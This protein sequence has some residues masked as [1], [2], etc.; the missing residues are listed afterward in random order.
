ML[1]PKGSGSA[2]APIRLGAWGTGPLPKIQAEPGQE[3]AFRLV[4][5][6]YWTV[7]HLEFSGGQPHGVFISGT[8]GV[9]HGIHIRDAVVH[10]VTGEPENKEGGLLVI[11]PGSARQTFDDV[12]VDGVTAY[13]TSQW[14]GILVGSVSLGF[15]PESARSTNVVV[16]NSIVHDVAGDGI[17]LFQVNKGLIEN[18]VAWHTGMQETETIGTPDG[19]WVWMCRDCTLRRNE[20]FLTDSPGIDGGAFDIDYGNSS[21]IVEDSYGHDTQGYCVS[22]FGAG[23]VT[24]DSVVRNNVCAGNGRSP[25]LAERQGA[26]FLSTWN[27]G[28]LKGVTLSGNRIFWD[29]PTGAAAV[30]NT[31]NFEGAGLFQDNSIHSRSPFFI[32][33]NR[34]LLFDRN[35]YRYSGAGAPAWQY[36]D[37]LYRGFEEYVRG[38]RQ[39]GHGRAAPA[40][41]DAAVSSSAALPPLSFKDAAGIAVPFEAGGWTLLAFV[42]AAEEDHDSRGQVAGVLSAHRQ[43]DSA[44]LRVVVVAANPVEEERARNLRYDWNTGSVPVVFDDGRARRALGLSA[45][46]SLILANPAGRVLWRHEGVAPPGDLGLALRSNLGNPDYAQLLCEP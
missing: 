5:Q 40:L 14:A 44:G 33:S 21:T 29:P 43:F 2:A 11:A 41:P 4:D 37:T 38:S 10:G 16:R 45:T 32:R 18:S 20:A 17:V 34:S 36:G 7:E 39:D 15:L 42:S 31:A 24:T 46:P 1:W 3:S 30:V 23:W 22:V 19:I 27:R 26:V 28:R 6:E 8:E 25:R 9:L 13:R 35:S 12:L